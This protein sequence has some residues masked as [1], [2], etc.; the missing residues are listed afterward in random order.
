MARIATDPETVVV[1]LSLA[2]LT[3]LPPRAL[4]PLAELD[5][6]HELDAILLLVNPVMTSQPER[7]LGN[8][9]DS[10]NVCFYLIPS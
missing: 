6:R 7:L 1:R 8:F 4:D 3:L 5:E 9:L 2:E 10:T